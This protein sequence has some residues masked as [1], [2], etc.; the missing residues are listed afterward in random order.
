MCIFATMFMQ[1][2]DFFKLLD[3]NNQLQPQQKVMVADTVR[4]VAIAKKSLFTT[5]WTNVQ[6]HLL[7]TKRMCSCFLYVA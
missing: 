1:L 3:P 5:Y 6:N 2:A 4:A 7:H